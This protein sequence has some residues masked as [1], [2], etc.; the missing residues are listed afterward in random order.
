MDLSSMFVCTKS[1][2]PQILAITIILMSVITGPPCLCHP[3]GPSAIAKPS[4]VSASAYPPRHSF[5]LIVCMSPLASLGFV[6]H[7]C[8]S[9]CAFGM[10]SESGNHHCDQH[11]SASTAV[12]SSSGAEIHYRTSAGKSISSPSQHSSSL[13]IM[14][15]H[16]A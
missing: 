6:L 13:L 14:Y 16:S 3:A 1:E 11:G 5:L 9:V 7:V 8:M 4:Q 2:W 10:V 15:M 12:F